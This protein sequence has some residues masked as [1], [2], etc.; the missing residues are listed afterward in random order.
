MMLGMIFPFYTI[1]LPF[2]KNDI[3]IF[4]K[5]AISNCIIPFP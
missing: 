2:S 5:D 3:F 1:L 4:S